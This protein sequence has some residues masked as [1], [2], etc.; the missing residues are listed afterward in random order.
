MI[1]FKKHWKY[2]VIAG[3]ILIAISGVFAIKN[4][5]QDS[6]GVNDELL[7]ANL[8]NAS[9]F[10]VNSFNGYQTNVD[11]T[12]LSNGAN[13]NGQNTIIDEG[14]KISIRD[15]GST[16]LG[17]A[18]TTADGI[19]SLHTFRRR[20]GENIMMRSRG[21]YLE[22]FEE[23]SDTW[24]SLGSSYT[25]GQKFGYADFN[26]NADLRSYVYFGNSTE[27]FSRWTGGKT[28]LST[29][30]TS[31][32]GTLF[33]DSTATLESSGTVI[34]CN[35]EVTYTGI[36]ATTITGASGT[37]ACALDKGVAQAVVTYATN[38]KG[39]IYLVSSN[40]LF[41][42][43]VASTTQAV[44][45]SAYTDA[46]DFSIQSIV[47]SSTAAAPGIFNL[48][49]G[50]GGVVGM[51]Q[52]EG[53]IYI[54]KNSIIYKATLTD[55]LYSI[56][57]LKPFDGKSQ[58][59]GATNND[60]IFT[61]KNGVFFITPDRQIMNLQRVETVDYPQIRPISDVI[62]PS[63]DSSEFATSTG[64][65]WQDKAYIA[66]QSENSSIND[67]VFVWNDKNNAWESPLIGWSVGA[68]TIYDD[69]TGEAL[70]FGDYNSANVYKVTEDAVDNELGITASWRSKRFN[71]GLPHLQKE[72]DNVF[73]SGYITSNTTLK[74]ILYI[75]DNGF[76][77]QYEANIVGTEDGFIYD[78]TP[79]NVFGLHEFGFQTFG[80]SEQDEKNRFY[81]YLNDK[82]RRVPFQN[83]QIEFISD[84][85]GQ[86]WDITEFGFYWRPYS[87]PENRNFYRGWL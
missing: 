24:E 6:L 55:S 3:I 60:S 54:Y 68:W 15:F 67:V 28:Q 44:F 1:D 87:Q 52:D 66:A 16:V 11:A 47:S 4:T 50:G 71:F 40:R 85:V 34:L 56:V 27:D 37:P 33:V 82:L 72:V 2:L 14:D 61:G 32:A 25:T 78:S 5:A 79:Q 29:A 80:S 18:T 35:T 51:V 39:N 45:F 36:T 86:A 38:P 62:K 9:W 10:I 21:T 7:G 19:T 23:G 63:I 43:G 17:T 64:I 46:T 22:Y 53:S 83:I 57:P 48:G 76:T 84:G 26:I 75:D 20:N 59:V 70:Y 30:S 69:G 12:K 42:S 41:V 81:L 65:Y 73:L 77:Q 13:P 8:P 58:T 31:T 49:E 74:V